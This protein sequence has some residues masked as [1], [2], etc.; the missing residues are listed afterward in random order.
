MVARFKALLRGS[1][2]LV[3]AAC[4][5]T[6][7][8]PR[9]IEVV[10]ETPSIWVGSEGVLRSDGFAGPDTLPM[11]LLDNDTV[12]VRFL[13]NG[14]VAFRA[15]DSASSYAVTVHTADGG[16]GLAGAVVAGGAYEQTLSGVLVGNGLSWPQRHGPTIAAPWTTSINGT[17]TSSMV[18]IAL[19]QP[20][21][22]VPL[23]IPDSL[24]S[25]SCMG[26]GPG[27]SVTGGLVLSGGNPCWKRAW[28]RDTTGRLVATDSNGFAGSFFL[29]FG[30][31]NWVAGDRHALYASTRTTQTLLQQVETARA[32]LSPRGDR[33]APDGGWVN[34]AL[35]VPVFGAGPP[36]TVAYR[37]PGDACFG[38]DFSSRGDTLFIGL[39]SR[40]SSAAVVAA[41]DATT[42]SVLAQTDSVVLNGTSK[43][44]AEPDR[45]W[46]YVL[47]F[48]DNGASERPRI[49]VIDRRSMK[50]VAH[51]D[52]PSGAWPATIH[53][54]LGTFLDAPNRRLYVM[55][56]QGPANTGNSYYVFRLID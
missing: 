16:R 26:D 36:V 32:V 2:P 51:L 46:I 38:A 5:D 23:G 22:P 3:A 33:A 14:R 56:P 19:S 4:A 10:L 44:L 6:G 43:V 7:Q 41:V 1:L 49:Y 50:V 31:G 8:A 39:G 42:G 9:D 53:G 20:G 27:P 21:Q 13:G 12:A 35:G 15:P 34:L 37:L 47:G 24:N 18:V 17:T 25:P 29:Y 11:V 52:L 45:P 28:S 54:W 40:G 55:E 48:A 30:G